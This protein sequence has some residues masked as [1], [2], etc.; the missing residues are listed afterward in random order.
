MP[1]I[2]KVKIGDTVK[3]K[4]TTEMK[5]AFPRLMNKLGTVIEIEIAS[6]MSPEEDFIRVDFG[7]EKQSFFRHRWMLETPATPDWEV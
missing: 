5:N 7:N 6:Y 4:H 1:D 3:L 2:N